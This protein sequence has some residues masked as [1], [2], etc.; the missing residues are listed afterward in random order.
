MSCFPDSGH[1]S[2][3]NRKIENMMELISQ[4]KSTAF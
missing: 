2:A 4:A 1:K 3:I